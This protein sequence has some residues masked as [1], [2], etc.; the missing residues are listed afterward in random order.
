MCSFLEERGYKRKYVEEQIDRARRT[1][2]GEALTEKRRKENA[3]VPFVITYHPGLPNIG[4]LLRDLH[5]VLKRSKRCKK[6]FPGVPMV[7]FRKPKSLAQYLVCARFTNV[8]KEKIN[9][10]LECTSKNCQIC[11]FLYLGDTFCSNSNGKN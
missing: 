3:R 7:A 5:P 10:T 6:D 1:S 8:P 9:G 11:N 2:R 4:S